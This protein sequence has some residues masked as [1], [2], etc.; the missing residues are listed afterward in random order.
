[1][2][3]FECLKEIFTK[4]MESGKLPCI[5]MTLNLPWLHLGKESM[6]GTGSTDG[7]VPSPC[8]TPSGQ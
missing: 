8:P 3:H 1:M 4:N 2:P 7:S 6:A 5:D